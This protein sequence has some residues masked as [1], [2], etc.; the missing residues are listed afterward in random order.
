MLAQQ[1]GFLFQDLG[2]QILA[3]QL[4]GQQ[5]VAGTGVGRSRSSRLAGGRVALE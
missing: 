5:A 3:F 2:G 1:N 4:L